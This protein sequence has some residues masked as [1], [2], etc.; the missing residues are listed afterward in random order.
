MTGVIGEVRGG[1]GKGGGG[2][3]GMVVK[4]GEGNGRTSTVMAVDGGFKLCLPTKIA[5]DMNTG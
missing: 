1:E 4:E 2:G 5:F 3:G